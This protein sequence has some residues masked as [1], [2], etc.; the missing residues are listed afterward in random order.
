MRRSGMLA[1]VL[2]V[3]LA[4]AGTGT[5]VFAATI[6]FGEDLGLGESTRLTSFP[7]ASG[8][9]SDFLANLVGVGVEDFEGFASGTGAPLNVDFGA[10]GSAQL[11]GSGSV[12]T[13]TSGTNGVG[14]Y[15][16]SGT[17]YWEAGNNF[18]IQFT[19][20][21]A[22]FG[23]YGVDIGDFSGQLTVNTLDGSSTLY[24]VG[25]TTNGAGGGV[26]Y[27]GVIDTGN[28]FTRVE[29][30]NTAPG[31]DYFGFDDF[32]IGS[33]EQVVPPTAPVPEPGTLLL[34]GLGLFGLAGAR[35][36]KNRH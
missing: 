18:A 33:V 7:N 24:N 19:D 16:I 30:G 3:F 6:Y 2:T 21:V 4:L 15:P 22:A 31:V 27:W 28:P 25:N 34:L 13:V 12:A 1:L 35:A 23:F 5:A 14:R 8:A 29:F 17:N 26:L 32:T 11:Q 9:Q 10:A 20:P 36:L